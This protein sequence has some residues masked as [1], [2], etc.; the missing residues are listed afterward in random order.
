MP[1]IESGRIYQL[2]RTA[3]WV[4]LALETVLAIVVIGVTGSAATG[5]R[6]DLHCDVPD[7]LNY[8]LAVV[9]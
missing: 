4:L 6:N 7:K 3:G 5:F 1:S 8:N 2:V 9:R